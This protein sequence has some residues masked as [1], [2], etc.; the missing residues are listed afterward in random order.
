MNGLK[1]VL[2]VGS[3]G[4]IGSALRYLLGGWVYDALPATTFP[5]GTL[6]VN[7]SGCLAIGV[8]GGLFGRAAAGVAGGKHPVW[9]R[10]NHR[11]GRRL[12]QR[13]RRAEALSELRHQGP[14][15]RHVST[16]CADTLR[17]IA[18]CATVGLRSCFGLISAP[19]GRRTARPA[20]PRP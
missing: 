15:Q 8:L 13:V 19:P 7:V 5:Y 10:G 18:L 4:F 20:G 2:L 17:V 6:V 9:G 11:D 14:R 16:S 1:A 12:R 3:G